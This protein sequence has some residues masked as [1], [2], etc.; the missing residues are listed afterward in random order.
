MLG[1]EGSILVD[2]NKILIKKEDEIELEETVETDGGYQ[3]EFEDFY[4]AI[5][6]GTKVVSSFSEAYRDLEVLI[7]ALESAKTWPH[8]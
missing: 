2:G 6:Q 8:I 4:L 5:R 7:S 1:N 3:A